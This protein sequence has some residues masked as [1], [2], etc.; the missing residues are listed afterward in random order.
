GMPSLSEAP[1]GGAKTFWLL[2]GR[3]PKVTRCK[4]GTHSRRYRSNGY[5]LNQPTN[6]SLELCQEITA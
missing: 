6:K 4:S 2:L 5:V 3:L 1:S